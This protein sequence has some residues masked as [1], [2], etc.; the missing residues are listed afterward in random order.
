[1]TVNTPTSSDSRFAEEGD[2]IA[3]QFFSPTELQMSPEEYAARHAH[4]L[5][6]FSFHFYRYRDPALGAWVRR[7]G[8]ILST[9][10]EVERY[11]QQFLSSEELATV[12]RQAAEGL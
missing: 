1:M 5:G 12:R 11:Q 7:V 4:A 2:W 6:C 8:E 10:G 3:Q 9:E